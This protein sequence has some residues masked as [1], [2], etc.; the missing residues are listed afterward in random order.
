MLEILFYPIATV[1]LIF[2]LGSGLSLLVLPSHLKQYALWLTPW[3]LIIFLIFSLIIFSIFGIAVET[4]SPF[5]IIFLLCLITYVLFKTKLRYVFSF[6]QDVL[7][8]FFVIVSITLNLSPLIRRHHFMT[9]VSMGNNDSIVYA[10]SS[11]FLVHHSIRDNLFVNTQDYIG[12]LLVI[13][14]RWGT[15]IIESFFLNVFNLKGYQYTYVFETILYGLMIPLAYIL[16]Q[17]I[18]KKKSLLA[19]VFLSLLLVFN[20]NMLYMVYHDFVGQI[21]FW[22]LGLSLLIF[23]YSYLDKPS[24]L[25]TGINIYDIMIGL[26]LSALYMSYHE[27]V[28]FILAPLLI[29]VV[30][31]FLLRKDVKNI[32]HGLMKVGLVSFLLSSSVIVTAT[33]NDFIQAFNGDPNAVIGWQ[34]FRD[35]VPFANPVEMIG[36]S[37]IHNFP[38]MPV[39]FAA[40]LS[41]LVIGIII[42]GFIRTKQ[43]L[44]TFSYIVLIILFLVWLM[45]NFFAYNRALTYNLPLILIL[46]TIGATEII[47]LNKK[48]LY[49]FAAVFIMVIVSGLLLNKRFLRE[50][51]II[52]KN[53]ISLQNL[54]SYIKHEAVYNEQDLNGSMPLWKLIWTSYFVYPE[55]IDDLPPKKLITNLYANSVPDNA[56]TLI[57]KPTPWFVPTKVVFRKKVWENEYY[58][59]GR[60]CNAKECLLNQADNLSNLEFSDF[61]YEDSLLLKGWSSKES[62]HRWVN[63]KEAT[64][65]LVAGKPVSNLKI[66]V[67]SLQKPQKMKVYANEVFIEEVPVDTSW[68]EY[69]IYIGYHEKEVINFRLEFSKL[70]NP[71][72]L[73]LSADPRDLAADIRKISLE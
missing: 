36:F 20:A 6:K 37:S 13:S 17:I 69:N 62:G 46:F 52:D 28:F 16:L 3:V 48:L 27:P 66:E 1:V 57:E 61:D 24:L 70:Y 68:N 29:Y 4:N 22:G 30:F 44:L 26:S 7:L 54:P 9:T 33:A 15:P 41:A 5:I 32:I 49:F 71:K 31:L 63:S 59:L 8:I 65:R 55:I 18:Y 2:V 38:P 40:I 72:T 53:F 64:F 42:Y 10:A 73:G 25:I 19:L 12:G 23:V 35:S 50:H 45:N 67:V 47:A 58:V 21:L 60:L 11:D 14:Y 39:F 34:L 51:A 43:K 56:L